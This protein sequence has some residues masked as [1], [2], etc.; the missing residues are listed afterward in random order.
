MCGSHCEAWRRRCF[1]VDSVS[2]LF[3]IQGTLTQHGYE[4][5]LQRYAIWFALS[6][7][8]SSQQVLSI[9]GNSFQTVGKAFHVKL[10]KR[11]PK[12]CKAVIKA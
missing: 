3:R 4:S 9:C 10:V 2:D 1:P 6:G 12:V 8:K 11:M 7:R 5:I